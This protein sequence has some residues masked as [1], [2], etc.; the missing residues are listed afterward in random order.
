[1]S[2]FKMAKVADDG[3][4]APSYYLRPFQTIAII[5]TFKG[6][7]ESL[8]WMFILHLLEVRAKS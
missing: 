1:M 5:D 3:T 6:S 4:H 7:E 2:V 8:T